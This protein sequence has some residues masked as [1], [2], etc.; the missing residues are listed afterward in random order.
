MKKHNYEIAGDKWY[1]WKGVKRPERQPHMTEEE[2]EQALQTNLKG[3]VH[4]W[5]QKGSEIACD[6]G[7]SVHGKRI[8]TSVRL[9]GTGPDGEPLLVP[10]GPIHRSD[11]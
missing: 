11:V 6:I 10:F 9:A 8:G 5:Y 2:L 7:N 4:E 1:D 3:H